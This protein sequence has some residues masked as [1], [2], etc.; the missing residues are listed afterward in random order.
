MKEMDDLDIKVQ[1]DEISNK[2]DS[3]LQKINSVESTRGE[4]GDDT[5]DSKS[6]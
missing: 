3:I 4:Q 6:P 5:P 1:L 2:I